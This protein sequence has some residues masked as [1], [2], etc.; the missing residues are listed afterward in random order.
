MKHFLKLSET[1]GVCKATAALLT[2]LRGQAVHSAQFRE[3][4]AVLKL[5]P[6]I[7]TVRRRNDIH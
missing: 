6:Y 1:V 4:K 3:H 5:G 2:M 7:V